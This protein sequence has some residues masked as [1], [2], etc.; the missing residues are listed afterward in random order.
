MNSETLKMLQ[1]ACQI[2]RVSTNKIQGAL[3]S[4]VFLFTKSPAY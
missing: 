4:S 1:M 3:A 2:T